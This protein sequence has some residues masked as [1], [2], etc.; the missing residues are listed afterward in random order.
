MG[1]TYAR[2]CVSEFVPLARRRRKRLFHK[3]TL[4]V[5]SFCIVRCE[6]EAIEGYHRRWG[7]TTLPLRDQE[8]G[9]PGS[10]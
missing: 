2:S 7:R 1:G 3:Y 6:V 8:D 9:F 4:F 10:E 5:G